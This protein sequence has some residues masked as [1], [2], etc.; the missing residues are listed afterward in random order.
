[1]AG[2]RAFAHEIVCCS[3]CARF[4]SHHRPP[5]PILSKT[6]IFTLAVHTPRSH[7]A[8][9]NNIY[10]GRVWSCMQ[11][12]PAE[13]RKCST[14]LCRHH[15]N[16]LRL[17]SRACLTTKTVSTQSID[18]QHTSIN[19]Y[20]IYTIIGRQN[21]NRKTFYWPVYETWFGFSSAST[22]NMYIQALH[23]RIAQVYS[24]YV[25]K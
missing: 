15:K 16:G 19:M 7:G 18:M 21:T 1:M 6:I 17:L 2:M 9:P 23:L 22:T 25:R 3:V 13:R 4:A 5:P 24:R 12:P 10:A 11:R 20:M 8:L 14:L